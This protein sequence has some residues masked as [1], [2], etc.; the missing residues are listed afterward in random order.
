MSIINSCEVR[1]PK[2]FL[3][4]LFIRFAIAKRVSF[5][6][7][8]ILIPIKCHC[9]PQRFWQPLQIRP[10]TVHHRI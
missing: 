7:S 2:H 8:K 9:L 5:E 3:G 4:V 1:K 10:D 6:V